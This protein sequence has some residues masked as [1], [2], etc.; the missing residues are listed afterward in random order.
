MIK[1]IGMKA[2]IALW[3]LFASMSL[4]HAGNG[5]L[6]VVTGTGTVTTLDIELCLNAA[7]PW[8]RENHTVTRQTLSIRT[9]TPNHTYPAAGIK[10]LTPGYSLTG[11]TFLPNG[12]C[13]FSVSDTSAATV[14]AT[15]TTAPT[16]TGVSPNSGTASGNAGVTLTGTSLTGTT[17]V[18]FGGEAATSVNVVDATTVTAVT[19]AHSAGEVDVVITTP[20]GTSTLTNGYTYIT[21]AVGQAS[22]GGVIACLNAGTPNNYLIAA[23]TDIDEGIQWGGEGVS[24]AGATST[25]DGA[26]NTTAIVNCLTNGTGGCTGGGGIPTSTYA[27]GLCSDYAV[28]SQGNSP[29]VTG[30]TCYTDWFLPAG[31]NTGGSGQ[32]NCLYANRVAIGGFSP[33]VYWSSTQFDANL[34]WDQFF[35]VG[36]LDL[37]PKSLD[38]ISVRC[39]RAFTP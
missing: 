31:D 1:S 21:T 27:A 25:T 26:A 30:N 22:G 3:I 10:V 7:T 14:T 11:C 28:D 37:N 36:D 17:G 24:I 16:L 20:Q 33:L 23:T 19:P 15:S 18:T 29:C 4:T 9:V 8:S 12:F 2:L 38:V 5:D 39:V 34:A 32:L 13:Q 6:F 35:D